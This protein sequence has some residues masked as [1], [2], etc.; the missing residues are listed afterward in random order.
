MSGNY[1]DG[2]VRFCENHS[3]NILQKFPFSQKLQK[4]FANFRQQF[5]Q[6]AEIPF[7]EKTKRKHM[8][9]EG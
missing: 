1:V 8:Y 6:K 4:K 7:R 2:N 3:E 5:L 9:S